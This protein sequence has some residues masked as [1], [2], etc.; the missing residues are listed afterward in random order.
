MKLLFIV[1]II[2]KL[3]YPGFYNSS[4]KDQMVSTEIQE[5]RVLMPK[6]LLD[7]KVIVVHQVTKDLR[8]HLETRVRMHL[9][10]NQVLKDPLDNQAFKGR[11]EVTVKKVQ[12]DL[13][14]ILARML[15]LV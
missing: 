1:Q 8:D 12:K 15:R 6:K 14:G 5:K 4:L 3:L 10:E 13:L 7:E 2:E 11:K 9:Q